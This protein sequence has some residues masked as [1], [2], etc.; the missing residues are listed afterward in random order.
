MT[1]EDS[2]M[3]YFAP[4]IDIPGEPTESPL[5]M[6]LRAAVCAWAICGASH[7]ARASDNRLPGIAAPKAT[8]ASLPGKTI[9]GVTVIVSGCETED[10]AG[11]MT[12][13]LSIAS[14]AATLAALS[15]PQYHAACRRPMRIRNCA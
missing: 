14:R 15:G 12:A 10:D 7:I 2:R 13:L 9:A 11:L 1:D 3:S 6:A 8:C 4:A 5:A